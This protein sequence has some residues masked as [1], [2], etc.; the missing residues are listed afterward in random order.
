[1][2]KT[3]S[4]ELA[5]FRADVIKEVFE[6]YISKEDA[7]GSYKLRT[8]DETWEFDD[9]R[10]F[11]A[12]YRKPHINSTIRKFDKNLSIS[13][14]YVSN[15]ETNIIVQAKSRGEIEEVFEIFEKNFPNSKVDKVDNDNPLT[16][17]IG[18]GRNPQWK[19]LK[20]HLSDKHDFK[21]EAYETGARAGHTIRDIL[22]EM[23]NKSSFAVLVMTAE[24]KLNDGKTTA[25]PNVIHEI[26]LFQGKL[27]FSKSI[28]L[29]ESGTEEFSNLHGI[30][31]IRFSKGNIKETFGETLATIKRELQ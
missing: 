14:N 15:K 4:F 24:D 13:I 1:M 8:S 21:I 2:E 22:E 6:K 11:F 5:Y 17:F 29:L 10:E 7:K 27:G 18:H 28:V 20:D 9:E 25:R 16:I 19:D 26:G 3:K 23:S 30:Q 31:Q 12:D